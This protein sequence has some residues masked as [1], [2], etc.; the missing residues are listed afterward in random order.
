MGHAAGQGEISGDRLR[1]I[2]MQ[3]ARN[4][5]VIELFWIG[6]MKFTACEVEGI[7]PLVVNRPRRIT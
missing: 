6:G 2:G 3:I 5:L 1:L 4:G 7:N